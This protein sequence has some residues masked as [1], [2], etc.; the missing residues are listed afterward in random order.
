MAPI[1]VVTMMLMPVSQA[2]SWHMI[3]TQELYPTL[4]KLSCF[5]G[6]WAIY[7]VVTGGK[8]LAFVSF[9]LLASAVHVK[10]HKFVFA[11]SSLVFVNYALPF[12][13]VARWS[14]AKLAKVI[15][16]AD[17]GT[18]ALMWGYIYKLYF[19]SNICLWVFV[20]YKV[21]TSFEGYRRVNGVQ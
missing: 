12:V 4:F 7:N 9:G 11:A 14:A 16:K 15:K 6:S 17:E 19:V 21:Y 18:L 13:F 10:N 1:N 20:I 2:V 3:L 5:Y 8:D